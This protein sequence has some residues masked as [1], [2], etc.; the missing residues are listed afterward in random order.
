M[1]RYLSLTLL[2]PVGVALN[3]GEPI[4]PFVL[5]MVCAWLA[6]FA[7]ERLTGDTADVGTREAFLVVA[8]AWLVVAAVGCIPYL[9]TS[10]P[11]LHHPIDAYFESMSGF[12]TT[13]ASVLTDIEAMPRSILFSRSMTQWLGGMGIV[14]LALA[15]LPRLRVGGQQLMQHEAPR[16]ELEKLTPTVRE[17]AR[18][19]WLVYVAVTGL[20]VL[21]LIAVSQGG[22]GG[23]MDLYDAVTH[24]FTT[25]ST[26][27]FS[28]EDESLAGFGAT[29]QWIVVVFMAIAGLNFALLYRMLRGQPLALAKDEQARAYVAILA[30]A[31]GIVVIA[32]FARESYGSR[33][34]SATARSRSPR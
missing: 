30:T 10:S 23:G 28:P 1:T 16:P 15:I 29:A 19:L 6:G 22:L 3:Y 13:G 5:P 20:E 4:G 31:I 2:V 34:R 27:G 25:L 12:T 9:L 32:L 18:R 7:A 26:G 11:Q 24:S 14:V 17:T 21:L 8:S 33:R